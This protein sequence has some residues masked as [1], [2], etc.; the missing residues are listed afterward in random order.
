MYLRVLALDVDGTL[1]THDHITHETWEALRVAQSAGISLILVT[2]RKLDTL[3]ALGPFEEL[4]EAIIAENG[5]LIFLPKSD[6]V[7]YPFGFLDPGLLSELHQLEIPVDQGK[8]LAATWTP[9]DRE[10]MNLLAN[11]QYSATLE[12]NK[13]AVMILPPGASKGTG[14]LVALRELGYSTHNVIA[15]GDGE[16]DISFFEQAEVAVAV[17]NATPGLK[18]TADIVLEESNGAGVQSLIYDLLQDDFPVIPCRSSHQ[19]ILGKTL[20]GDPFCINPMDLTNGNLL[21]FGSSGSGKSWLAGLLVEKLLAQEYQICIVDPE[22][23][24]T[25]IRAFPHSLVLGGKGNN[26]SPVEQVITLLEY[27]DLSLILDLSLYSLSE[28]LVY[29]EKVLRGLKNLRS[30]R[31][32]PHWLLIDEAHYFCPSKENSLVELIADEMKEGGIGIISYRPSQ[33]AHKVLDSI[34]HWLLTQ[35]DDS[36][37]IDFLNSITDNKFVDDSINQVATLSLG[38]AWAS[39]HNIQ[40]NTSSPAIIEFQNFQRVTPHIRHLNKYLHAPLPPHKQFYFH[41]KEPYDGPTTAGSLGEFLEVLSQVPLRSLKYHLDKSH[42]E[43]W[44]KKV[45]NDQVL[46]KQFGKIARRNLTGELMREELISATQK[47]YNEL[48]KLI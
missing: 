21:I 48:E 34:H 46:A 32:K 45:L 18:K 11:K 38:K 29:V 9:H 1:A 44:L 19:L 15:C 16:N 31:G 10:L 47:R 23:D 40:E 39:F 36:G 43:Q 41:I 4:F 37:E 28:K 24:Y 6:I 7:L 25:G 2:G 17:A 8:V 27:T 30:R 22:G 12:Y 5:G 14:L 13:G 35:F 3:A 26:Q 20:K 42:F 33:L